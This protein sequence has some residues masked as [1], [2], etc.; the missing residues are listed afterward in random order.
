MREWTGEEAEEQESIFSITMHRAKWGNSNR[1][2]FQTQQRERVASWTHTG[3]AGNVQR[4]KNHG[5]LGC[6]GPSS[7]STTVCHT[8]LLMPQHHKLDL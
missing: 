8:L 6:S 1:G 4:A 5:P 7:S 2:Q 3:S